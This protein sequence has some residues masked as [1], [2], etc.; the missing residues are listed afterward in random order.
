MKEIYELKKQGKTLEEITKLVEPA[1]ST[2]KL[3][4]ELRAY[5]QA[6]NLRYP[7]NKVGRK[8]INLTIKK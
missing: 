8:K 7:K 6:N 3:S 5:C 2:T 4:R 1:T